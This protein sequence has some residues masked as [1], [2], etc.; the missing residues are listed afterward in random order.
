[1]NRIGRLLLLAALIV[2]PLCVGSYFGAW[3][4]P[5]LIISSLAIGI[6]LIWKSDGDQAP[7]RPHWWLAA[8][9]LWPLLQGAWMYYNAWGEFIRPPW[10]ILQLENQPFPSLPGTADQ[11]EAWD[12][13]SYII[14]CLGLVWVTRNLVISRPSWIKVIALTIFGTGVAVA[15]LG[16]VQRWTGAE[17]IF[18]MDQL[19]HYMRKLFFATF[20]SPGIAT[21]CLNMA[22]AL[23]LSC[24]LTSPDSDRDTR[25]SNR[26]IF[27][28]FATILGN[29]ILFIAILSAGSKAGMFLG[30]LTLVAWFVLN[31]RSITYAFH[32]SREIF[33]G[34]RKAERN[35]IAAAFFCILLFSTASFYETMDS[36]WNEARDNSFSSLTSRVIAYEEQVEMMDDDEWGALGFGPGSFYPLFYFRLLT[37]LN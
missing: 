11:S 9:P 1:V 37:N 15:L 36:R 3:R 8:I 18:W 27:T 17:G 16:L 5:V 2:G 25:D 33:P 22:F 6:L 21:V 31:R 34:G 12:R 4:L 7:P 35:I 20:R 32:R 26:Y 10:L 23:G 19:S 24:M 13:L 29:I 14:P 30:L 28:L